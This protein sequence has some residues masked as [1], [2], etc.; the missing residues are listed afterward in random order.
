[1]YIKELSK[2]LCGL[3][4]SWVRHAFRPTLTAALEALTLTKEVP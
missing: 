3:D 2:Q 1:M 4:Y